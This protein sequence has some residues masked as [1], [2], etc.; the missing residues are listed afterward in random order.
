LKNDLPPSGQTLHEFE[1]KRHQGSRRLFLAT[2]GLA[3][4]VAGIGLGFFAGSTKDSYAGISYEEAQQ[5]LDDDLLQDPA[6][7]KA[8]FEQ[9]W[10]VW[11]LVQRKY[12]NQPVSDDQLLYG[13]IGGIVEGLDDPYSVFFPPEDSA[14]FLDEINGNFQG[15][16]AEVGVKNELL[17]IIAPL[18]D[19]PAEKA[20]LQA[21]DHVVLI[22][23]LDTSGMSLDAAVSHIRGEQGT[24]VTLLIERAG[25]DDLIEVSVTRDVIH[26]ESV[27]TETVTVD[28]NDIVHLKLTAFNSDTAAAFDEAVNEML[29][30]QP[31]GIILDMRNN[32][33]GFLTAA[34]DIASH[35][36]AP[37]EIVVY[38]ESGTSGE[39]SYE[40]S[41][42][43]SLAGIPVV[44][45]I[46]RGSASAAEI[47]AG[48]LQDHD[49]AVV[50]GTESF[51]K[52]T[53]QDLQT[54]DDGS[55]LKL[56]VARWLTPDR[57]LIDKKGIQPD[58]YMDRTAEDYSADVD[59]QLDLAEEY[60]Q[61]PTGF[62][63]V[64]QKYLAPTDVTE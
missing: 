18:P 11:T 7:S 21:G 57:H 12:V 55:S 13:A 47:L 14:A 52:G 19:S 62:V 15:I 23:G 24:V 5:L 61:D 43:Q 27:Q 51:G 28:G 48:A 29:L 36:L 54:F 17:T 58:Y 3:V 30:Q 60:F 32:A 45:L 38:E 16:G 20:G 33:G 4:F 41:K 37:G 9:F 6:Q 64:K 46:N 44:V 10:R 25:N 26:V 49:Q 34:I 22:D 35:F 1:D 2:I 8:S 42:T 39:K 59:P 40:A 31:D 63:E 53:V 50:M 56:T